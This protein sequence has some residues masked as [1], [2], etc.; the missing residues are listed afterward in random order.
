MENIKKFK[1]GSKTTEQFLSELTD[2]ANAQEIITN[3][4]CESSTKEELQQLVDYL[5]NK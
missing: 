4:V 3:L 2:E 1:I 5:E